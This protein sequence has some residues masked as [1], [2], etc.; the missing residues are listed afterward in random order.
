[1]V[2]RGRGGGGQGAGLPPGHAPGLLAQQRVEEVGQDTLT[3][4]GGAR[5]HCGGVDLQ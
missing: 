1:M 5:L 3:G 2:V 4:G